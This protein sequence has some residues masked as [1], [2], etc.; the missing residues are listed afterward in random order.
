MTGFTVLY[1]TELL[2][3]ALIRLCRCA[4]WY[5]PLLFSGINVTFPD[6]L[7]SYALAYH[8]VRFF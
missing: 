2:T 1:L 5:V 4:D 6:M 8:Y 7:Y 3:N